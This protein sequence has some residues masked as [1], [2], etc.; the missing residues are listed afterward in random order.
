MLHPFKHI[1]STAPQPYVQFPG[2]SHPQPL[3]TFISSEYPILSKSLINVMSHV[4]VLPHPAQPIPMHTPSTPSSP[5]S[6]RS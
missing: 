2:R 6:P 4:T 3:H 1:M 5:A